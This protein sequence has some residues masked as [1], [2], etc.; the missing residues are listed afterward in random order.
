MKKLIILVL[1]FVF[2]NLNKLMGQVVFRSYLSENHSGFVESEHNFP[3]K[4]IEYL[5]QFVDME[6]GKYFAEDEAIQRIDYKL[7]LR[8]DKKMLTSFDVN[9]RDLIKVGGFP[10]FRMIGS[11]WRFKEIESGCIVVIIGHPD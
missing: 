6:K 3:G 8:V 7:T 11:W 4:K 1:I 5:W 10:K 9:M 2:V